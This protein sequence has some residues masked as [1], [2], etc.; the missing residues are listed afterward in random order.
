[1]TRAIFITGFSQAG[2]WAM[3]LHAAVGTG[4]HKAWD[5]HLL[6]GEKINHESALPRTFATPAECRVR[7][8][9]TTC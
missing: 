2:S 4:S 9:G 1:M 8:F 6:L 3:L 7:T 5:R